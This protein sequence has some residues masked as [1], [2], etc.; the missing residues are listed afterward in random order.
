MKDVKEKI[1]KYV[2]E[3]KVITTLAVGL[4]TYVTFATVYEKGCMNGWKYCVKWF[5]E[6][7]DTELM[8][9]LTEHA[10]KHPNEKIRIG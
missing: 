6:N 3:H 5:D 7:Y 1:K 9:K 8:Q 10:I 2:N 4:F